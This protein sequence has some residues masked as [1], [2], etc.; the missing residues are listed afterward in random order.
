MTSRQV[1]GPLTLAA[2][3]FVPQQAQ[4]QARL[5]LGHMI[6]NPALGEPPPVGFSVAS[7][8]QCPGLGPG[9]L[10]SFALISLTASRPR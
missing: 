1:N 4:D 2:V 9:G 5:F 10:A 6:H 7:I 8:Q 3:R